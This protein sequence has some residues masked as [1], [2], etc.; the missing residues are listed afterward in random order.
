MALIH[1]FEDTGNKLFKY[2]GQIPLLLFV[3]G[4]PFI[5]FND[6][7]NIYILSR[8]KLYWILTSICIL[9]SFY[10]QYIRAVAIGT[11]AK[12]TSGRNT[13][14]QVADSLNTTGIYSTCRHPLYLG[15]FFMWFGI[16]CYSF[17]P[18]FVVISSLLF[19]VYYERIMFAE[20]RFLEKKFGESYV[21]WSKKVPAFFQSNKNKI[22]NNIPFSMKTILRR[23]YSGVTA[24][25]ISFI[26]ID[27]IRDY[28]LSGKFELNYWYLGI[29][30]FGL[31]LSLVL[32]TLKHSTNIL[33]EDDRS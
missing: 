13:K 24:T 28:A 33:N 29:I 11:S 30:G 32:R 7:I 10:G 1:S 2:R 19:W 26:F 5:Y 20:E 12:H 16:F 22:K 21:A 8:E 6:E 27:I 17:N 9:L 23:E 18:Y 15:N 3:L 25:I 4:I 31:L 14:E